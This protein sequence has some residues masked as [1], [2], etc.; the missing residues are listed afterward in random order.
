MS[1]NARSRIYLA[2]IVLLLLVIAA[3]A[4]KFI[5][6]GSV[7]KAEDGRVAILLEP[8]ERD[9]ALREMRGFVAGLHGGLIYNDFPLMNGRLVPDDLFFDQPWWINFLERPGSAQFLH[10]CV[11]LLVFCAVINFVLRLTGSN[12][13]ANLKGRG[14]LLTLAVIGQIALGITT[15]VLVVPVAELVWVRCYLDL[16]ARNE[17][18]D[19]L[20]RANE[21]A[22]RAR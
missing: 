15:L 4:Y 20:M 5:V 6:A 8:G 19:L 3:M 11:A 12:L 10:R 2:V 9:F 1:E 18:L 16:R 7:Q 13:P 21:L 17:G 22:A 14:S